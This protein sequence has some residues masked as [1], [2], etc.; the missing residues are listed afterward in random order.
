M[1]QRTKKINHRSRGH[2][3]ENVLK[4]NSPNLEISGIFEFKDLS[5]I[6]KKTITE[7][8]VTLWASCC[9]VRVNAPDLANGEVM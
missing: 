8:H 9:A 6:I 1:V 4:R 3:G 5:Y 7:Q 2:G